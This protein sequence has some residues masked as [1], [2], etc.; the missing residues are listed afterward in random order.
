MYMY[1]PSSESSLSVDQSHRFFFLTY[2]PAR[3]DW[4]G[5]GKDGTK[6]DALHVYSRI[7]AS[8]I[9]YLPSVPPVLI[10]HDPSWFGY[11]YF[12]F[13]DAC[14]AVNQ[15]GQFPSLFILVPCRPPE[16]NVLPQAIRRAYTLSVHI[17]VCI[18]IYIYHYMWWIYEEWSRRRAGR[19]SDL[20]TPTTSHSRRIC[21]VYVYMYAWS[22][23]VVIHHVYEK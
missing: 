5:T 21:T 1:T 15:G 4:A 18:F 2:F 10:H 9:S 14:T 8:R 20:D 17:Y 6:L 19:E 23:W 12:Q 13:R 16:I 7:L 3:W 22:P 11:W